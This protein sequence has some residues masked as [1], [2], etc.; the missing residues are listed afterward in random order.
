[1]SPAPVRFHRF[2][3]ELKCFEGDA[4]KWLAAQDAAGAK[5]DLQLTMNQFVTQRNYST[6]FREYYLI[7]IVRHT[8]LTAVVTS[9]LI[10]ALPTPALSSTAGCVHLVCPGRSVSSIVCV[11]HNHIS[12]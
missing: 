2:L 11:F 7:P 1:M 3:Y 5:P 8:A 6:Y 9:L 4:L 10:C 12:S